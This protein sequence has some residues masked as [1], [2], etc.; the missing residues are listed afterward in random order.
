MSANGE[1]L[2]DPELAAAVWDLEPLVGGGGRDGARRFLEEAAIR[3]ADF[4]GRHR[5]RV[6]QLDGF[7]LIEAMGELSAVR[8]ITMRAVVYAQLSHAVHLDDEAAGALYQAVAEPR[9]EVEQ[10]VRFF[11][12]EWAALPDGDVERLLDSAGAGLDFAAHH[13]RRIHDEGSERLSAPRRL[14]LRPRPNRR[15]PA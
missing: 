4:A 9:L 15:A 3:A 14:E 12:L 7:A 13:L 6:A 5:G 2:G 10:T 8:E 11:E 1:H